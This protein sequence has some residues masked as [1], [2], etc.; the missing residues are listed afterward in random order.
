MLLGIRMFFLDV[1][2][3]VISNSSIE[4]FSKACI[5]IS[6]RFGADIFLITLLSLNAFEEIEMTGLF[7]I[8]NTLLLNSVNIFL[9]QKTS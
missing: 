4:E 3:L 1:A 7:L 5:S 6:S 9:K 2:S 8:K